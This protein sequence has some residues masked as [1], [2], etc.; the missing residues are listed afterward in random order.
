MGKYISVQPIV[1]FYWV[2]FSKT[3]T[4]VAVSY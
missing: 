2:L 3:Y 1:C 4:D